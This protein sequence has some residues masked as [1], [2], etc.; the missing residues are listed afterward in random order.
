MKLRLFIIIVNW[1]LKNDT[2][3]CIQSLIQA[4]ADLPQ[5]VVVD[6]GSNDGSVD[7]LREQFGNTLQILALENNLGFAAG[8]NLGI[9]AAMQ[10]GAEWLLLINNDTWVAADFFEKLFEAIKSHPDV[11]AFGPAIYYAS[12]S[13]VIWYLGDRLIPGT[14]LTVNRFRGKLLPAHLP[15][16]VPV[17]FLSGCAM[18]VKRGAF[19]DAGL[20]DASLF[21]YGEEVDWCWRARRAG[22]RLA[23]VPTAAMWHKI[24]TS[25][26]RV[27]IKARSLRIRNQIWVYRRHGNIA[28]R[29]LLAV[30]SFFRVL[31]LS[32]KDLITGQQE[33]SRS[34]W[35]GWADGWRQVVPVVQETVQR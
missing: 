8:T 31:I 6:N 20:L 16:T 28:Q 4:G 33:L 27:S 18:L 23:A 30:F 3:A 14:M 10:Q 13:A 29:M 35:Q 26:N 2:S 25:S 5:I 22:H 9:R 34:D 1:N 12:D 17:D 7:Y 32:G 15:A 24:S 19:E 11:S 21:M